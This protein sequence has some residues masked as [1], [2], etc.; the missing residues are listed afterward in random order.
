M[1]IPWKVVSSIS[2]AEDLSILIVCVLTPLSISHNMIVLSH[3]SSF[4]AATLVEW[5]KDLNQLDCKQLTGNWETFAYLLPIIALSKANRLPASNQSSSRVKVRSRL[6]MAAINRDQIFNSVVVE[7]DRCWSYNPISNQGV[8]SKRNLLLPLSHETLNS[9][10]AHAFSNHLSFL[11]AVIDLKHLILSCPSIF[12]SREK[13]KKDT[14]FLR[15]MIFQQS[16]N[17]ENLF[18]PSFP[19]WGMDKIFG[20]SEWPDT[21][22]FFMRSYFFSW[23]HFLSPLIH[24]NVIFTLESLKKSLLQRYP[25]LMRG[26]F[27]ET[28]SRLWLGA[29][30][31]WSWAGAWTRQ[32]MP[33]CLL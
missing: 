4:V 11:L 27:P 3:S 8:K 18:S 9:D 30:D 2:I 22:Q 14:S 32:R 28:S 10:R 31:P 15:L 20:Q 26:K 7:V 25:L 13:Q 5:R 12:F 1:Q 19:P 24:C 6:G 16:E 23:R 17:H 29:G 21:R 33:C